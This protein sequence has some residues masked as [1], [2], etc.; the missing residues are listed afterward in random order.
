[1]APSY[2]YP[3]AS[4]MRG[5]YQRRILE[6]TSRHVSPLEN[7]NLFPKKGVSMRIVVVLFVFLL[8]GCSET[9]YVHNQTTGSR[10]I[11]DVT[12]VDLDPMTVNGMEN[13]CDELIKVDAQKT[14]TI[15]LDKGTLI[16]YDCGDS[17]NPCVVEA[18]DYLDIYLTF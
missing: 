16:G 8:A 18:S 9:V 12:G 11:Y 5:A 6:V 14:K 4:V 2:Q 7:G 13:S 3:A 10:A 1:M 17:Y 15:E